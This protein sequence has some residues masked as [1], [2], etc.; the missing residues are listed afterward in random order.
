MICRKNSVKSPFFT[1]E[2][3]SKFIWRKNLRGSEFL[4]FFHSVDNWEILFHQKNISWNQLINNFFIFSKTVTFTKFREIVFEY[5]LETL[6]SRKNSLQS[7]CYRLYYLVPFHVKNAKIG[8]VF[9][10][11]IGPIYRDKFIGSPFIGHPIKLEPISPPLRS[12]AFSSD[13]QVT[14]T[15]DVAITLPVWGSNIGIDTAITSADR[16]Q[17]HR[18]SWAIISP[19]K[20]TGQY[21]VVLNLSTRGRPVGH[22]KLWF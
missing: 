3:Y 4:V 13:C 12:G 10:Q 17:N 14:S 7:I 19:I 21:V 2:L 11:F 16:N 6:I 5:Y 9:S 18:I 15:I 22:F 1:K 20:M 8:H